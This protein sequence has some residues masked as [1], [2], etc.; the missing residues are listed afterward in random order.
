MTTLEYALYCDNIRLS[1]CN[2]TRT[3]PN[4]SMFWGL[5]A[6]PNP[7]YRLIGSICTPPQS[8]VNPLA[9][10]CVHFSRCLHSL[11]HHHVARRRISAFQSLSAISCDA[12]IHH[13]ADP[14]GG[15]SDASRLDKRGSTTDLR[16][17]AAGS[18]L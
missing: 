18:Y 5:I 6:L 3:V 14:C 15:T 9:K 16:R 10:F 12:C 13:R 1:V 4:W 17:P 11:H 2:R 8:V 7:N